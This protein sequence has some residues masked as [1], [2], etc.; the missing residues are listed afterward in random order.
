[1][2]A[3][4]R[5]ACQPFAACRMMENNILAIATSKMRERWALRA[6]SASDMARM[7]G[8][9]VAQTAATLRLGGIHETAPHPR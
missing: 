9:R 8:L 6:R 5:D 7:T 1:M 3:R 4:A 2:P